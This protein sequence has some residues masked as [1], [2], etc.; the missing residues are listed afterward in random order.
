MET[1]KYSL[2]YLLRHGCVEDDGRVTTTE[3]Q[4]D[5][6][7]HANTED[8]VVVDLA[9]ELSPPDSTRLTSQAD[10]VS[11]TASTPRPLG[12]PYN[13]NS[14]PKLRILPAEVAAR[15]R[16]ILPLGGASLLLITR[17]D[18][19]YAVGNNNHGLLGT[20]PLAKKV[21]VPVE[22][23]ELRCEQVVQIVAGDGHALA[24]TQAGKL[25]QWGRGEV[26]DS[27]VVQTSPTPVKLEASVTSVAVGAEHCLALSAIG[28]V[29]T[30][31]GN[32]YGQLG[33]EDR[34]G[35]QS[36]VLLESLKDI[37]QIAAG[38]QHSLALSEDGRAFGW[39]SN[40]RNQLTTTNAQDL[41]DRADRL[42]PV[43]LKLYDVA[44]QSTAALTFEAVAA[45]NGVSLL[46]TK[47]TAQIYQ[48]GGGGE[49]AKLIDLGGHVAKSMCVHY[50]SNLRVAKTEDNQVY[51][52]GR[53]EDDLDVEVTEPVPLADAHQHFSEVF[54]IHA[55]KAIT[56]FMLERD[57]SKVASTPL[58]SLDDQQHSDLRFI[59]DGRSICVHREY[60]R[61]VSTYFEQMFGPT[62]AWNK[63]VGDEVV[64]DDVDYS[65]YHNYLRFL[66]EDIVE[67]SSLE[68]SIELL[69]LACA[70]HEER[71]T[72]AMVDEINRYLSPETASRFYELS[73]TFGLAEWQHQLATY[74]S[75]NYGRVK[76][77][78]TFADMQPDK[79]KLLLSFL[80][81]NCTI[82]YNKMML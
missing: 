61:M 39:G 22:V 40:V 31:G 52:W 34:T 18:R 2:E 42:A 1:Q 15:V 73:V 64:L 75:L 17:Y 67:S 3:V 57:I 62:G 43:E 46:L 81:D 51:Y 11:A 37:K 10:E 56:P 13:R 20:G 44:G 50:T 38:A 19:V 28:L 72:L 7:V 41:S 79:T 59:I 80:V 60:L 32:A 74:I 69:R 55:S 78:A 21:M 63:V 54:T 58:K 4:Q 27:F 14:W 30:W 5:N 76:D 25:W 48:L 9:D 77:T 49:G 6:S 8:V 70:H 16:T 26:A 29:F 12:E 68:Q 23:R 82:E 66:Y 35:R 53:I 45:G 47:H 36:P 71:L 33:T 24:R 65:V